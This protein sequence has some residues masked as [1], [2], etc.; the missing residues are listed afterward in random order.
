M[1]KLNHFENDNRKQ[2]RD[3]PSLLRFPLD[4]VL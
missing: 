4:A 3:L 1:D 2:Y